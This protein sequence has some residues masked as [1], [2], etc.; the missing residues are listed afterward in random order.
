MTTAPYYSGQN[1]TVNVACLA[2]GDAMRIEVSANVI[3]TAPS[4]GSIP[5]TAY[6][7]WTSLPGTGTA[8]NPTGTNTPGSSGADDGERNG[9]GTGANDY[10]DDST[11]SLGTSVGLNQASID[12]SVT[13]TSYTIG[14]LITYRLLVTLAEGNTVDLVVDDNIPA[15]FDFEAYR[16][17]TTAAASSGLLS[18]DYVGADPS[19]PTVTDDGG[20][21]GDVEFDF[22]TQFTNADNDANNN[23]FVIELDV[24]VLDVFTSGNT[25]TN[26]DG[27]NQN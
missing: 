16:V 22:G 19:S 24:R 25:N 26:Y 1:V 10:A 6:L 2:P 8:G 18:A 4:G 27:L 7:T 14:D 17:I 3:P 13:P 20:N 23:A 21:G 11:A 15:G 12:K 5:N 9:S